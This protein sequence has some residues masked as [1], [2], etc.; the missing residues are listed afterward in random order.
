MKFRIDFT[1]DLD[2]GKLADARELMA[3]DTN[4][5]LAD[6]LRREAA[7][8][9]AGYLDDNLGV[10]SVLGGAIRASGGYTERL[11]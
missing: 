3:I 1:L 2:S 8:F 7:D 6:A 10:G 9:L 5:E 4:T 11:S